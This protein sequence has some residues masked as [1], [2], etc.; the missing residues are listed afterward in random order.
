MRF[1]Y[2]QL[3]YKY[4]RIFKPISD[5][6]KKYDAV[7]D[8]RFIEFKRHYLAT[9]INSLA[10]IYAQ[11]HFTE[12]DWHFFNKTKSE[13]ARAHYFNRSDS[14]EYQNLSPED[15]AKCLNECRVGLCLSAVEGAMY[16]SVQYLLCGLPVVSTKSLGGRDVFFDDH[17][18][19][20]VEPDPEAVKQGV[21]DLINRNISS[22]LIRQ[23]HDPE[24][25][26]TPSDIYFIS[27][28]N[29]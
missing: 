26:R 27:P 3:Y 14:G 5:I 19:S 12:Q 15:I 21:E 1:L 25:E 17:Y 2:L 24:N 10:L 28:I 4:E 9:R 11:N 7:Y 29:L 13:L 22:T 16:A 8:A 20:L 18:V 6:R 23:K